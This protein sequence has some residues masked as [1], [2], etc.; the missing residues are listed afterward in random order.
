ME[1]PAYLLAL[2]ARYPLHPIF[3]H[4]KATEAVLLEHPHVAETDDT[5]LAYT[6]NPKDG[7]D[8]VFFGV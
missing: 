8:L 5:R 3:N 4:I 6:R 2:R 1:T 7:E